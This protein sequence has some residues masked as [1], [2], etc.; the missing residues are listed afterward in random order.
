MQHTPFCCSWSINHATWSSSVWQIAV[1]RFMATYI[2]FSDIASFTECRYIRDIP[3]ATAYF[4]YISVS[5][6]MESNCEIS[7]FSCWSWQTVFWFQNLGWENKSLLQY[8]K[9]TINLLPI[10]GSV[11]SRLSEIYHKILMTTK[12]HW[13]CPSWT[14]LVWWIFY[15]AGSLPLAVQCNWVIGYF[16][17]F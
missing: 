2:V 11:Q 14:I 1:P 10:K 6:V 17:H 7:D 13:F 4:L 15:L 8:E 12:V 16:H 3:F 5:W 9:C